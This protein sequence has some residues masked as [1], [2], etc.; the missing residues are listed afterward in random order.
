MSIRDVIGEHLRQLITDAGGSSCVAAAVGVPR[1][2][3][4]GWANGTRFPQPEYWLPLA[5]ACGLR[6][7]RKLWPD[8][9]TFGNLSATR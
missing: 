3:V 7:Y 4:H 1:Q 6:D 9:K 2:T 5:K 8:Q